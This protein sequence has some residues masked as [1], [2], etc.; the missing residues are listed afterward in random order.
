MAK[1]KI[2]LLLEAEVAPAGKTKFEKRY[3]AAT[4]RAVS[5]GKP[6]HYQSQGN[7]WGAELRGYF[8]DAAMAKTLKASGMTVEG[9]RTGYKSG[10]FKYRFNNSKLW[11]KL[12][13]EE[14]L[15]LGLN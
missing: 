14:G 15:R 3:Q 11:W 8:N 6:E 10:E 7:K 4:G 5:A 13:E 12:V 9:P 1:K 2:G